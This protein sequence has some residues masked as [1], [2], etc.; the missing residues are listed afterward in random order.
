[1]KIPK[2]KWDGASGKLSMASIQRCC[3]GRSNA[4]ALRIFSSNKKRQIDSIWYEWAEQTPSLCHHSGLH[5]YRFERAQYVRACVCVCFFPNS[6]TCPNMDGCRE[7]RD[8][9]AIYPHTH[10]FNLPQIAFHTVLGILFVCS[11]R[12]EWL[13]AR[14]CANPCV[15]L[16]KHKT[17]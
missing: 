14:P 1:M 13:G 7:Y 12:N 9:R 8:H 4:W 17:P 11:I 2:L 3:C 15:H 16:C 6:Y 5:A 10:C